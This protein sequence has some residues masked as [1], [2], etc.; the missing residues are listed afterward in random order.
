M[1]RYI[2]EELHLRRGRS[3]HRSCFVL[4]VLRWISL[5]IVSLLRFPDSNFPGNA[6]WA[7][8][9]QPIQSGL[10]LS[11]TIWTPELWFGDWLYAL[12]VCSK[13]CFDVWC[14]VENPSSESL[15]MDTGYY[16]K[17]YDTI[18]YIILYYTILYHTILWYVIIY[19]YICMCVYIYIYIC[20]CTRLCYTILYY[21][22]I[23]YNRLFYTP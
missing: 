7:W 22:T 5:L 1:Y 9:F 6:R 13:S 4:C 19:H 2:N 21:T 18:L 23:Y 3:P 8:E 14:H 16:T 20:M 10:C 15:S 11:Q 12:L 17:L